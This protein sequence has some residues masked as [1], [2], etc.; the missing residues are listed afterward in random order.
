MFN[1]FLVP[2]KKEIETR[3]RILLTLWAYAY[4][5]ENNSI[6]PDSIFDAECLKV[7]LSIATNRP[8][9]DEWWRKNFDS[10]TGCWIHDHP[11]LEKVKR[12]YHEF[13]VSP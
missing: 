6:V 5:F 10:F 2:T 4:E 12:L 1:L 8:D 9:L 3:R 7:D 13:Y 11:E